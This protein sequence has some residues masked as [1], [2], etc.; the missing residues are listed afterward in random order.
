MVRVT[1]TLPTVALDVEV[2][3]WNEVKRLGFCRLAK[4]QAVFAR[5]LARD[6]SEL[7]ALVETMPVQRNLVVQPFRIS[8]RLIELSWVLE[9][10]VDL[11][12]NGGKVADFT[13]PAAVPPPAWLPGLA[14][15]CVDQIGLALSHFTIEVQSRVELLAKPKPS[16]SLIL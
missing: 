3:T 7:V 12:A 11:A 16:D 14:A 5:D 8:R 1:K 9:S 10:L 6:F 13:W 2:L 15:S 4:S